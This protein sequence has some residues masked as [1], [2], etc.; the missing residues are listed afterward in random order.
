LL[1][2]LRHETGNVLL[3]GYRTAHGAFSAA[4][5]IGHQNHRA[6]NSGFGR[7]L[8]FAAYERHQEAIMWISAG[9]ELVLT[10]NCLLFLLVWERI[11]SQSRPEAL[12]LTAAAGLF[13][14][15]LFSK[16]AAMA[17]APLVV[18][19]AILLGHSPRE[20]LKKCWVILLMS[21]IFGIFWLSQANRNFFVTQGHYSLSMQFAPV[22]F[23]TLFRLIS[24]MLPFLAM[25]LIIRNRSAKWNTSFSALVK[26]RSFLF[27]GVLV[28]LTVVPYSFLTYL[29]HIP[30]RNTY[31][32]SVGLA[33]IN[34]VLFAATYAA[35]RSIGARRLFVLL[36]CVVVAGNSTYIWL[37][38]DAQ[39]V[40]RSAPTRALIDTL[41]TP[42]LRV[43]DRLPFN[44]CGFPLHPWIGETAVTG[45]TSFTKEEVLFSTNCDAPALGTLLVWDQEKSSYT[46][47]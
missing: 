29:D 34:G 14:L 19:R 21:G 30:S 31:F 36:L 8:F 17:L 15:S 6:G 7:A 28:L 16:E 20:A 10:L 33:G 3:G 38:K 42:D 44:V 13:G 24:Q 1:K 11:L 37:K 27:F 23:R 47:R 12:Q 26:D 32:P 22:Y 41:N 40:E 4:L 43:N 45:F 39:Y 25:F 35:H 5:Q 9:N 2:A 46:I 18:A